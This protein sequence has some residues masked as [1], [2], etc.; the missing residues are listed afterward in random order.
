MNPPFPPILEITVVYLVEFIFGLGYNAW[1]AWA[2]GQRIWH[3]TISVIVGVFVVVG[4][5]GAAWFGRTAAGW[6]TWVL[7]IGCFASSGLPMALFSIRRT[8][9]ENHKRRPWPTA[10]RHALEAALFELHGLAGQIETTANK[11][12]ITAG[13]LITIVNRIYYVIGTLKSVS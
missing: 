1:V 9:T 11:N 2:Q 6:Q 10:A 4:I 8:A 5:Y 7:L 12:E 3:V 13:F